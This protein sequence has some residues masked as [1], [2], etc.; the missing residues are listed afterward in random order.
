MSRSTSLLFLTLLMAGANPAAASDW[1]VRRLL[2]PD[3]KPEWTNAGFLPL[4]TVDAPPD[5]NEI[6]IGGDESGKLRGTII[7]GREVVLPAPIPPGLRVSLQFKSSC[8]QDSPP[9]SGVPCLAFYT[10]GVWQA[11]DTS[12]SPAILNG[13]STAN[14][15][16][17]K[18]FN[19]KLPEQKPLLYQ[20]IAGHGEDIVHWRDWTSDNL[21]RQLR[22]HAG[23]PLILAL[24]WSGHHFHAE[25]KAA[26]RNIEIVTQT[27]D[28]IQ[29][30]FFHSLDLPLP[31]LATVRKRVESQDWPAAGMALADYFRQRTTP[32]PPPL[33]ETTSRDYADRIC[34]HV[35]TLVGCGPFQLDREIQ[36]NEDP[37]DYEQWAIALNRHTH[38]L[39]LGATYA[40][41]QDEKYAREFVDQLRSWIDAMPVFI[42]KNYVQGPYAVAGR[43][44]LSLDAGIRMGQTWFPTFYYF[45]QSPS[46]GDEDLLAMLHSFRRH[47]EY[48]MN[49]RHF[50]SGSNWGAMESSGLLHIG[51]YL[52]EFRD[53]ATWRRTAIDRLY[54]ELDHQVYPDGAQ[55][56]LTPGYHGVTLGNVL[57]AVQVAERCSVT[58]PDDFIDKLEHM[59]DYYVRIRKPD[60][61]TPAINDSGN[62]S[63]RSQMTRA[64]A[65]FPERKDFTYFA[66][67]GKSGTLPGYTSTRL[68]Y[69]GWHIMRSGWDKNACYLLLDAGPFGTGHQHED[70]LSL[71]V[72]AFGRT[73]IPEAGRYSY[74]ASKWR[75]YSLLTPS[76]N[77]VMVDGLSQ[78]HR[79]VRASW[80]SKQPVDT[81][82]QTNELVD[83]ASASYTLGYGRNE[84]VPV[85]HHREVLFIKPRLWLVVDRLHAK[86]KKPHTYESLFHLNADEVDADPE[87]GVVVTTNPTGANVALLPIEAK[88]W[89]LDIVKGQEEPTVQGW[90]TTNRHN[91]LRPVPTA[92]YR[93]KTDG[94]ATIAYLI[95]PLRQGE[96]LPVVEPIALEDETKRNETA[97]RVTL[98]DGSSYKI[99]WNLIPGKSFEKHTIQ[100]VPRAAILNPEGMPV[101]EVQQ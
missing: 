15:G 90:L 101:L 91:V 13:M 32:P 36:W 44:P 81:I 66:T 56:E 100:T 38:W 6:T 47:A 76:H 73:V 94:D 8:E 92:V 79:A 43:S 53:A 82:W 63:V 58:L 1:Q 51:C 77:T 37:F 84:N 78:R 99:H 21:T 40:G 20:A 85:N 97:F 24:V 69:A 88:D 49:P 61:T 4:W 27:E 39:S 26:F 60:D 35:F 67:N 93:Y 59:F 30:E 19:A 22:D 7:V 48:L 41:T 71:V 12:D 80:E 54:A 75:E 25:E 2:A 83:Y 29:R 96:A 5:G 68:D 72:H 34:D 31:H 98:P 46:F 16:I 86:D 3:Q 57:N 55:K 18:I 65:L 23:K 42:G 74:D 10:P 45:L 95:A 17:N 9:R 14:P 50:R 64:V 52:P 70:K 89:Q 87:T 62:S 28:D 11:L 33:S